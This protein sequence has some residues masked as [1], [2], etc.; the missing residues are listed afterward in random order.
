MID[1]TVLKRVFDKI[2]KQWA[3]MT[4]EEL[5]EA[6]YLAESP[7]PV[8]SHLRR[9]IAIK[10]GKAG[11][12]LCNA[13]FIDHCRDLLL[14]DEL[15]HLTDELAKLSQGLYI[16]D[17]NSDRCEKCGDFVGELE[18]DNYHFGACP[19]CGKGGIC[20]NIRRS[21]YMVCEKDKVFW[22]AGDNLLSGWRD[23]NEEIWKENAERLKGYI[24]VT[25]LYIG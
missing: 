25:A 19:K 23:E 4:E 15:D 11:K 14:P 6:D 16:R 9:R 1:I 10:R 21:N 20:M 24:K 7:D 22:F 2:R 12:G 17:E 5:M 8:S 3:E 18:V 13:C